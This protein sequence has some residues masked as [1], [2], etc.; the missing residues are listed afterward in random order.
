MIDLGLIEGMRHGDVYV[1]T[2]AEIRRL[3]MRETAEI[4]AEAK[5]ERDATRK[6]LSHATYRMK[7]AESEANELRERVRKYREWHSGAPKTAEA[8]ERRRTT[9]RESKRRAAARVKEEAR[10]AYVAELIA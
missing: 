1:L 9:W 7:R 3:V 4:R 6:K 8:L 10:A 5:A 2:E